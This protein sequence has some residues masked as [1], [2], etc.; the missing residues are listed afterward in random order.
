MHKARISESVR[1]A[2]SS[3]VFS[4]AH[5]QA[6][7]DLT[8]SFSPLASVLEVIFRVCWRLITHLW[9]HSLYSAVLASEDHSR[10]SKLGASL[11]DG[12]KA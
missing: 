6:R 11:L 8:F 2:L 4:R 7:L 1:I 5:Y 10:S 9:L 12:H 3:E